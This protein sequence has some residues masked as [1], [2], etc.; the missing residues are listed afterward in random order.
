LVEN[1]SRDWFRCFK[2]NDFDVEDKERSG[3]PRK[4]E[5]L[6]A[7]LY[8]DSC[9]T[10]VELAESLGVDYTTVSKRLKVLGIIR[11]IS[12]AVRVEAERRLSM[13]E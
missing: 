9:Q 8:E 12:G 5:E 13:C 3:G 10:L 4:F 2:N 1:N 6:K 11:R 7:L